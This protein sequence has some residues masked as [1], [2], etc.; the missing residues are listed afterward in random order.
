MR[1]L[2]R[3]TVPTM[4]DWC[5]VHL[6]G[7]GGDLRFVSGAHRDPARDLLVRALCEYGERELPLAD[8]GSGRDCW[9]S[10]TTCY[11]RGRGTPSSSSST[12]H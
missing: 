6:V 5:T 4:G 12:A 11:V 2:A 9:R 3:L 1:G 8:P 10:R 7:E